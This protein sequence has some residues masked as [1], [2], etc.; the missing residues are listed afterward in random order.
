[1]DVF[2]S[3]I[4]A[5]TDILHVIGNHETFGDS[6]ADAARSIFGSLADTAGG[7]YSCEYANVR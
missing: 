1:M 5:D 2:S 4:Y 6:N 3:G 7:Y